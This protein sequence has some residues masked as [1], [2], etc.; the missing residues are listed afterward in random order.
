MRLSVIIPVLNEEKTIEEIL[1]RVLT[2]KEVSEVVV[3][4]DGSTD[5]TRVIV[6]SVKDP[7]VKIFSHIKNQGKGAAIRTGIANVSGDF[8]IIQDADL[9]YDPKEYHG[10]LDIASEKTVVYGSRLKTNNPRAYFL[11]Y[12]G[13]VV[14]TKLANF[15][16]GLNLTDSYTCYKLLPVKIA[17]GLSLSSSGFEI[18]AEITAKLGKTRVPVIEIPISYQPRGYKAGKKIKFRDAVLGAWTL[19]KIRLT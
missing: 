15:F 3:V 18:E 16:F 12:L 9:E 1:S 19:L 17:K 5:K 2:Q 4:D 14:L 13:N 7:R 6:E 8:M 10:H 11:T